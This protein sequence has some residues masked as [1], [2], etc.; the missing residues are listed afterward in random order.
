[1][2]EEMK[3]MQ[4]DCLEIMKN[5]GSDSVDLVLSDLPY[6]VTNNKWDEIIPLIPMWNQLK[7]ITKDSAAIILTATQPFASMLISS[8]PGMFRYDWIWHKTTPTGHLNAKKMPMRA[9]ESILVFYKKLPVYNPQKTFGHPRKTSL[10]KHQKSGK[11]STNYNEIGPSDYD[12]TERFPRS[13]ITFSSDKQKSSLH[14]TQKPL[15]LIEYLILTYTNPGDVVSD[16]AFGS[17]TTG[18]GCV[19]TG[20]YFIGIELDSDYFKIGKDRIQQAQKQPAMF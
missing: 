2:K 17:C 6:G 1:M 8:N 12:S 19:K 9:H 15:S 7:R 13:V 10:S 3:L 5:I 16:I 18:V 4:G 14:P 20:R 11:S